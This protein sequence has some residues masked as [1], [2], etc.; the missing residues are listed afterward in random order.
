MCAGKP[1]SDA[2]L[3]AL[4]PPEPEPQPP[5]QASAAQPSAAVHVPV[6]APRRSAGPRQPQSVPKSAL[7]AAAEDGSQP[8]ASPSGMTPPGM[9]SI[10][11][12]RCL[13]AEDDPAATR[14]LSCPEGSSPAAPVPLQADDSRVASQRP[15][16]SVQGPN[17]M[18][19]CFVRRCRPGMPAVLHCGMRWPM[20][21]LRS[22]T[23]TP[24]LP[25]QCFQVVSNLLS[26]AGTQAGAPQL[27]RL[28]AG[29]STPSTPR[30]V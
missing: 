17:G 22:P 7:A 12:E 9:A 20:L 5:A 28:S 30:Q 8:A 11:A 15:S 1:S 10:G 3:A 6:L 23:V 13:H 25:A 24:A 14:R 21:G 19:C 16:C 27:N 29:L 18:V 2:N 26:C 4:Q